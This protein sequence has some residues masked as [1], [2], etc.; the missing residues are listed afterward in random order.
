MVRVTLVSV[1]QKPDISNVTDLVIL[2][3]KE[4]L[5]VFSRLNHFGQPDHSWQILISASDVSSFQLNI[6]SSSDSG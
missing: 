2:A 6:L 4:R 1:V 5:E 3:L